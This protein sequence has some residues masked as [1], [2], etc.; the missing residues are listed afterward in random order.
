MIDSVINFCLIIFE[1]FKL[2]IGN[3]F[4]IVLDVFFIFGI[5]IVVKW[6]FNVF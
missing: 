3:V 2:V 1:G 6:C 4:D 5:S